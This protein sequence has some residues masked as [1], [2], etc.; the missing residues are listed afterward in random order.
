MKEFNGKQ[1]NDNVS[2]LIELS[3]K[4]RELSI[5]KGILEYAVKALNTKH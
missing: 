3:D 2:L 5:D 4:A 1:K